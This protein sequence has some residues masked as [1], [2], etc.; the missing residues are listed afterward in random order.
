LVRN[1]RQGSIAAIWDHYKNRLAIANV[2]GGT[3]IMYFMD[4]WFAVEHFFRKWAGREDD[5]AVN[6]RLRVIE[7]LADE[8]NRNRMVVYFN[9]FC[10]DRAVLGNLMYKP[11]VF[12]GHLALHFNSC[13]IQFNPLTN[14]TKIIGH[15][16]IG[17]NN[18]SRIEIPCTF[19]W[20]NKVITDTR[21]K[22]DAYM[23]KWTMGTG[24]GPGMPEN[25]TNWAQRDDKYL[26]R[27]CSDR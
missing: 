1:Y 10:K 5:V 7:L 18:I 11:E 2:P 20:V 19:V 22:Y 15:E 21:K 9:K 3:D 17:A 24:S 27:Y 12:C 23:V 13:N 4:Q 6:D 16:G 8:E 14:K 25:F 26:N